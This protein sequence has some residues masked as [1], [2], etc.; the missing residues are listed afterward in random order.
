MRDGGKILIVERTVFEDP[1]QSLVTLLADITM[2]VL[3]GGQ[4][5]TNDEYSRL[6]EQAGL[7]LTR[8][9][10]VMNPYSIFEGSK[11]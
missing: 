7:S 11:R 10:P 2:L 3:T 4:E 5:R 9:V 8:V 1:A 6:F